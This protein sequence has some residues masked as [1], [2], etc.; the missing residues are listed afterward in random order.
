MYAQSRQYGITFQPFGAVRRGQAADAQSPLRY[1]IFVQPRRRLPSQDAL[2]RRP[3]THR[4]S[5]RPATRPSR[6]QSCRPSTS[7]EAVP[8]DARSLFMFSSATIFTWDRKDFSIESP[9]EPN[10]A[11][12][13]ESRRGILQRESESAPAQLR[14]RSFRH[15]FLTQFFALRRGPIRSENRQNLAGKY[16][17]VLVLDTGAAR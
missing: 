9:S 14:S 5:T 16:R 2:H 4:C 3:I 15:P 10:C 11:A 7:A 12:R 8:T 6:R 1:R 13:G 17:P